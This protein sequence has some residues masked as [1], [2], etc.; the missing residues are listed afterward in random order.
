MSPLQVLE[1]GEIEL[2]RECAQDR[3][4]QLPKDP[5]ALVALARLRAIEGKL[6]E[7]DEVLDGIVNPGSLQLQIRLTRLALTCARQEFEGA[8]RGYRSLLEHHP[9]LPDALY[10]LAS[11]LAHQGLY[12]EAQPAFQRLTEILP[13]NGQLYYHLGRNLLELER[14]DEA[15]EALATSL[16]LDP[17][18]VDTY[19]VLSRSLSAI[20]HAAQALELLQEGLQRLP[21]Q[22]HLSNELTNVQLLLG[23]VEAAAHS[24]SQL[25]RELPDNLPAQQNAALLL[26]AQNRFQEVLEFCAG[27]PEQ[28]ASLWSIRATA[29]EQLGRGQEAS[30]AY[31][32]ASKL[33]D[34]DWSILNNWGLLLLQQGEDQRAARV[35]TRACQK[36]RMQPEP[37]LNLALVHA[38]RP[39]GAARALEILEALLELPR[40]PS[41]LDEQA[42]RLQSVLLT[43]S[44][45]NG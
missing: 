1:E 9:D 13:E 38:R 22:P 26:L 12:E 30:Q 15:L 44:S 25:A 18:H 17:Y 5:E 32:Q 2:A 19:L 14:A 45:S 23:Q 16:E 10:G 33:A 8:A 24:A 27:L 11:S 20:G 21:G 43:S 28:S 40:L 39:G 41:N 29:L 34:C 37:Y 35:L 31:Q 42:R 7:A 3:L 4:R 6:E 36:A